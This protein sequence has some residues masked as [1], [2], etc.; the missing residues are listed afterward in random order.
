MRSTLAPFAA[1]VLLGTP[2][3]AESLAPL[4]PMDVFE[5]EL[6]SDPQ[7]A[8]DGSRVAYVRV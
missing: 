6:G 5:L 3:G 7:I 2:A 1:A 8:P 4:Q